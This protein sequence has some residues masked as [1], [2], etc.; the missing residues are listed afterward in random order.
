[1]SSTPI[2]NPGRY[3]YYGSGA[4]RI[5]CY[6]RFRKKKSF[7]SDDYKKF[8]LNKISSKRLDQNLHA[9]VKLGYLTKKRLETSIKTN[10][11]GYIKYIYE[12]TLGGHH[13]LVVIAEQHRKR[14]EQTQKRHNSNSGLIRWRQEQKTLRFTTQDK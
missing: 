10:D 11:Y 5:L 14:D 13:A 3:L 12:I 7:S 8:V 6:A 2:N 1:M 9:L 4:Y